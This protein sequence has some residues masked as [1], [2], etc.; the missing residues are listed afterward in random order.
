M[1][2]ATRGD[3]DQDRRARLPRSRE[4]TGRV[5]EGAMQTDAQFSERSQSPSASPNWF[6]A[7]RAYLL[8]VAATDLLWE[9]VHL[10][11]YTLWQ[12]GTPGEKLFAVI[13]CTAGDVLIALAALTV[14]LML[15]GHRDWP[16]RRFAVVAAFTL[17]CGLGYT[18]FS[19][20]LNVVVQKSWAYSGLMPVLSV[21]GLNLGVSPLVQWMMVP[22]LALY[23]SCRAGAAASFED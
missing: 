3:Y 9:T 19:E 7:L 23:A 20:W 14:G 22:T 21:F 5:M 8:T 15:A 17:A 13:H 6:A 2:L 12:T 10:P 4:P 1:A 16:V 18:I 11:L